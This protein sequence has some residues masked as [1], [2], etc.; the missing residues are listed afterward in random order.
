MQATVCGRIARIEAR[1]K[2][3]GCKREIYGQPGW[4][5]EKAGTS[6]LQVKWLLDQITEI[7]MQRDKQKEVVLRVR[8]LQN[9]FDSIENAIKESNSKNVYVGGKELQTNTDF[10]K[11]LR[12]R[13]ERIKED[14]DNERIFLPKVPVLPIIVTDTPI[15]GNWADIEDK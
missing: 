11:A 2:D 3:I 15:V 12:E 5:E 7:R 8:V 13:R 1:I 14:L 10:S 9:A 4:T 6:S